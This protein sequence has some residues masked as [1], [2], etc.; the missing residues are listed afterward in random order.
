MM[1]VFIVLFSGIVNYVLGQQAFQV[2]S[3]ILLSKLTY[4]FKAISLA[5][6]AKVI[7]HAK[8]SDVFDVIWFLVS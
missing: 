8:I 6:I 1:R 5:T 7:P 2:H 4:A 3:N